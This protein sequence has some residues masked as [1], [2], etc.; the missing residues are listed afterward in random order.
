MWQVAQWL[1]SASIS[2]RFDSLV[3]RITSVA[4]TS[5]GGKLRWPVGHDGVAIEIEV[6]QA[7]IDGVM[8]E[9]VSFVE[10]D[11]M[12]RARS[13]PHDVQSRQHR[14]DVLELRVVLQGR[15]VNDDAVGPDIAAR[16]GARAAGADGSSP[17][18][19]VTPGSAPSVR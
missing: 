2:S 1:R 4:A 19:T 10:D 13:P 5:S 12:W 8:Q 14:T 15:Q 11:P 16:G 7:V 6:Q 3:T 18:S 17:P 9:V